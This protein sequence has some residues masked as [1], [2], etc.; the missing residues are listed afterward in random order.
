V[1]KRRTNDPRDLEKSKIQPLD[2]LPQYWREGQELIVAGRE[3]SNDRAG[4]KKWHA[5]SVALSGQM[6]EA[7]PLLKR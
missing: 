2:E 7:D 6:P 5:E 3:P 4:I 1:K